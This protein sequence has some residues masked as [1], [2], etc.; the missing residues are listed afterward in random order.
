[1]KEYMERG[2]VESGEEKTGTHLSLRIPGGTFR[3]ENFA[4]LVEEDGRPLAVG[5]WIV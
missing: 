5:I 4:S 3:L 2:R 1:M